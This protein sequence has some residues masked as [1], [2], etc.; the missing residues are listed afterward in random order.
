MQRAAMKEAIMQRLS[1]EIDVWLEKQ[2]NITSGYDYETEFMK[3]ARNINK[4]ILE[5]S[6]GEQ[7]TSRNAKKKITPALGK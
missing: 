6:L 5:K 1:E 7:P 3:V 2:Q 4:V